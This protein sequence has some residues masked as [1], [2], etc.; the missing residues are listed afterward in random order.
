MTWIE[1]KTDWVSRDEINV[2]DINRIINNIRY[3]QKEYLWWQYHTG[4]IQTGEVGH[5]KRGLLALAN[6]IEYAVWQIDSTTISE[7]ISVV[8]QQGNIWAWNFR[9]LNRIERHLQRFKDNLDSI[10]ANASYLPFIMGVGLYG[11]RV[12]QL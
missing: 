5:D 2:V 7:S 10:K 11:D 1:P 8:E 12:Q 4:N 9:D 6:E 3:L